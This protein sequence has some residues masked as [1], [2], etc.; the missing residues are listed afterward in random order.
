MSNSNQIPVCATCGN[1]E[2]RIDATAEWCAKSRKWLLS[3][4]FEDVA[5]CVPCEDGGRGLEQKTSW[6][7]PR[8]TERMTKCS[9]CGT[10]QTEGG[11]DS[12]RDF[13]SRVQPGEIIPAGDCPTCGAFAYL[14]DEGMEHPR[15]LDVRA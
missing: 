13:W 12:Y 1:E 8:P 3:Q 4:T 11:L 14:T 10:K 6:A 5:Y 9:N 15:K 2:V 7:E